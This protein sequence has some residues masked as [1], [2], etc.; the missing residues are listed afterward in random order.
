LSRLVPVAN[1]RG[2]LPLNDTQLSEWA[3]LDTFD[4]FAPRYDRPQ[5]AATLRSWLESMPLERVEV[6]RA[7]HLT[8]RATKT[9]S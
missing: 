2:I 9:V 1:Y 3:L 4:W 7:D 6:F 5:T 8:G